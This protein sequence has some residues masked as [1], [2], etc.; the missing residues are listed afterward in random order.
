[1]KRIPVNTRAHTRHTEALGRYRARITGE[2]EQKLA[3]TNP[4]L[5][6]S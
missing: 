3:H 1:M 5:T 2:M 6:F 4:K